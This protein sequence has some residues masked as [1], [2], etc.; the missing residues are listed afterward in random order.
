MPGQD[1]RTRDLELSAEEAEQYKRTFNILNRRIRQIPGGDEAEDKFGLF[2]AHLQLSILCNHGTWQKLFSWKK[3]D[4]M[5][6]QDEW[7]SK[8]GLD[9]EATC[10]GCKQPRPI[11]GS[12]RM[13]KQFIEKCSHILC[14][15]CLEDCGGE[16]IISCPLCQRFRK[17]DVA[18]EPSSPHESDSDEDTLMADAE[19]PA[20]SDPRKRND[21]YFNF[22]GHST[23]ME[24]LVNDVKN[25]LETTKR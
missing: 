10:A 4:V 16:S 5:E 19:N 23:K 12:S 6:E 17:N 15:E 22:Q 11:L 13:H 9:D 3:R 20:R 2:Q 7:V 1:V 21:T 8:V 25:D 18:A 24:A 14:A